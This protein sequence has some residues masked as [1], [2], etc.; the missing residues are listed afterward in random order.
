MYLRESHFTQNR[1]KKRASRRTE[2]DHDVARDACGCTHTHS[3]TLS[4]R[5]YASRPN[6]TASSPMKSS[7][8]Q[9]EDTNTGPCRPPMEFNNTCKCK[10][11]SADQCWTPQVMVFH[12]IH[13]T[14]CHSSGSFTRLP[15]FCPIQVSKAFTFAISEPFEYDFT[16]TTAS[17]LI[18]REMALLSVLFHP[19]VKPAQFLAH[20]A[21]M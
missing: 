6:W 5:R 2:A 18:W 13:H 12:L 15:S 11:K 17:S 3:Q 8:C 10:E 9:L 16:L 19:A 21:L 14:S 1:K 20:S 7:S 4:A